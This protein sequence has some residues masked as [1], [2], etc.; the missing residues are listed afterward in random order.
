MLPPDPDPSPSIALLSF[1]GF[2]D[3]MTFWILPTGNQRGNDSRWTRGRYGEREGKD[4]TGKEWWRRA[5]V[6]PAVWP[7]II[8]LLNKYYPSWI[9][10]CLSSWT[11]ANIEFKFLW[12]TYICKERITKQ[13]NS[14]QICL[15][16]DCPSCLKMLRMSWQEYSLK[17]GDKGS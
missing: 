17:Q 14:D 10:R 15:T 9:E 3:S 13:K 7:R 4:L 16:L 8:E 12:R 6:M 1:F 5:S 11:K 2:V